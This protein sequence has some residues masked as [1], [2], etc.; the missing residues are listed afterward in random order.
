MVV[1]L[2]SSDGFKILIV[3][4]LLAWPP[5]R[6]IEDVISLC[7]KTMYFYT[8]YVRPLDAQ[9]VGCIE[10]VSSYCVVYMCD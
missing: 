2:A 3:N 9:E 1:H 4:D 5:E 7:D 8:I 10:V 6:P